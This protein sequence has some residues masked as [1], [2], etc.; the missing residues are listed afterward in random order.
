[1]KI[2]LGKLQASFYCTMQNIFRYLEPFSVT[3]RQMN[4]L[5]EKHFGL[6]V[7]TRCMSSMTMQA[8][9]PSLKMAGLVHPVDLRVSTTPKFRYSE[10]VNFQTK[11]VV[12]AN[13]EI[14]SAGPAIQHVQ[15]LLITSALVRNLDF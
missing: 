2:G 8:L 1:M 6:L 7:G 13:K 5:M 3:D 9:K 4:I 12:V 14:S 11:L 15:F 10:S